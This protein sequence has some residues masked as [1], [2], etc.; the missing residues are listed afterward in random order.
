MAKT[1]NPFLD[2]DFGKFDLASL[3]DPK[4]VMEQ[5]EKFDFAQFGKQF[6]LSGIDT[7]AFVKTQQKNLEAWTAANKLAF[8][9][10]QAVLQREVEI[11]RQAV[12]ETSKAVSELSAAET[13]EA[14]LAK[15]A[16]LTKQAYTQAVAN[17]RE[18][19]ELTAK[20]NSEA[21]AVLTGRFT[22]SLDEFKAQVTKGA[23]KK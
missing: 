16:D 20:S 7:N 10:V 9:G 4:K 21:A 22:E 15:Q 23:K 18:L 6:D 14:K 12:E 2:G 17:F 11:A 3:M 13:P 19:S 8:E 1:G 5:V